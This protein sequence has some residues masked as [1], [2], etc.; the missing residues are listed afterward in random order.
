M[1]DKEQVEQFITINDEARGVPRSILLD[2]NRRLSFAK[3][4]KDI[5]EDRASDIGNALRR[6]PD[7]IF[8]N[9][10]TV[11]ESPKSGQVSLGNFV[12]KVAPLVHPTKGILRTRSFIEQTRIIENYFSAFRD[13]FPGEWRKANNVFLKTVGFGAL[14]NAFEDVYIRTR[15]L[16]KGFRVNDIAK[17]LKPIVG[18]DFGKWTQYG[19][20]NKAEQAAGKDLCEEIGQAAD[21]A[22]HETGAFP[23]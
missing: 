18:F 20:G 9:R 3:S 17:L 8:F 15:D 11:V 7:S 6:N 13:V 5:S 12:R 4:E 19:T 16:Y 1:T 14:M 22:E 10:I 2:L 21:N 23:L